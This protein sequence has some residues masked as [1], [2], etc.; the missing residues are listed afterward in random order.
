MPIITLLRRK[1]TYSLWLQF[2]TTLLVN[3]RWLLVID[4]YINIIGD[5]ACEVL[6]MPAEGKLWKLKKY[7]IKWKVPNFRWKATYDW[8]ELFKNHF[9]IFFIRLKI[10]EDKIFS[11]YLD[12]T[13]KF[14]VYN[15]LKLSSLWWY[16][17]SK[18]WCKRSS[19]WYVQSYPF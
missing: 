9:L 4:K 7:G 2:F 1:L 17:L 10:M 12:F 8:K 19:L 16:I 5:K 18:T 13:W 6:K 11:L 14:R 3:L 15:C